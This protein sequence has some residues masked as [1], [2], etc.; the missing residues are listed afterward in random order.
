MAVREL[1]VVESVGWK[2]RLGRRRHRVVK[3]AVEQCKIFKP[4]PLATDICDNCGQE[5]DSHEEK[6]ADMLP[7]KEAIWNYMLE[8]GGPYNYYG[9]YEDFKAQQIRK[10]LEKCELDFDKMSTPTMESE[11]EFTGTFDTS[12]HYVTVVKGYIIC[13]CG[14]FEDSKY[15]FHKQD[16][17]VRDKTLSQLIWH[18]VK[19][20]S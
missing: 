3:K 10:H 5:P 20:G 18:V 4:F 12:T 15:D 1:F 17:C 8:V 13:K 11:A 16:W 14:E 9:Y 19:A 2:S 7:Y 6:R